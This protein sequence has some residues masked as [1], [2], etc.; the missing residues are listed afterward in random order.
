[1]PHIVMVRTVLVTPTRLVISP[2]QQEPSNS[3]TR[4]Y[5]DK[6]DAVIRV[7]FA[8]EEDKLFV[9][10]RSQKPRE[11]RLKARFSM[12]PE[13]PIRR[14]KM[15]A[16]WPEF[17]ERCSM[18]LSLAAGGSSRLHPRPLSRSQRLSIRCVGG[19]G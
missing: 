18:A 14:G 3:V 10:D 16:S 2:P 4:R 17:A 15:L 1:M 8:D 5:A 7:Q 9:S 19:L 12:V 11:P 6:I 13:R